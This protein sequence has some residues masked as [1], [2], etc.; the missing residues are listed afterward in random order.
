MPAVYQRLFLTVWGSWLLSKPRRTFPDPVQRPIDDPHSFS[1]EFG[2]TILSQAAPRLV[3]LE[4]SGIAMVLDWR[5]EPIDLAQ[6]SLHRHY[7]LMA[8]KALA[9]GVEVVVKWLVFDSPFYPCFLVRLTCSGL[10]IC[11]ISVNPSLGK[12]PSPAA[13]SNEQELGFAIPQT[14]TNCSH[15]NAFACGFGVNI[16]P[17][18]QDA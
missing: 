14:I 13:C 18:S 17:P 12:C 4:P 6:V 3:G 2:R 9:L 15:M 16:F 11:S 10:G 7:R 8:P 5:D 1:C